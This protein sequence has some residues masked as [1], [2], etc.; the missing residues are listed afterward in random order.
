LVLKIFL[1]LPSSLAI[2]TI[3]MTSIGMIPPLN[4]VYGKS[5][6]TVVSVSNSSAK[7]NNRE[8]F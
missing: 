4:S 6:N 3:S 1:R 7:V 5:I 8:V 2:L